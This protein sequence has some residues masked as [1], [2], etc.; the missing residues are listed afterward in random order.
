MEI[1]ADKAEVGPV[2]TGFRGGHFVVD[3]A[4]REGAL[5]LTP[6]SLHPWPDARLPIADLVAL[7]QSAGWDATPELLILGT[8]RA[9][10]RPS[11]QTVAALEDIGIGLEVVDSRTAARIWNVLRAEGRDVIA[12]LLPLDA[13]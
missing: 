4:V 6:N 12:A 8:G 9:I 7:A 5:L 2:I 11:P 3:G 13:G 10:V 1:R